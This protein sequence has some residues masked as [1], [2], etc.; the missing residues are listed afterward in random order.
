MSVDLSPEMRHS[1]ETYA[2]A[3]CE[4]VAADGALLK[5]PE[6]DVLPSE[7]VGLRSLALTFCK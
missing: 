1:Y 4:K 2:E 5:L 6:P 7:L 3:L